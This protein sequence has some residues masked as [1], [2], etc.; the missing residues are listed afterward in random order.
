MEVNRTR[1]GEHGTEKT[2]MK[3]RSQTSFTGWRETGNTG[4]LLTKS[5]ATPEGK[6]LPQHQSTTLSLHVGTGPLDSSRLY[7]GEPEANE[8]FAISFLKETLKDKECLCGSTP[9]SRISL[10]P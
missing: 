10:R 6:F 8:L 4:S 3:N 9:I 1:V 5:L 7:L 2:G